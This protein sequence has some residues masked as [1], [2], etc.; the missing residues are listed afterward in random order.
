MEIKR[1][2]RG[3]LWL[4]AICFI[5]HSI[6]PLTSYAQHDTTLNQ[7][8][9]SGTFVAPHR[10]ELSD[11]FSALGT[12][13]FEGY[14]NPA[15]AQCVTL[16][17]ALSSN[18]NYIATYVPRVAGITNP[19]DPNNSTCDVMAT[20]Q[21]FDG[22]GRPV[23]TV[24]IKG[25]P[26]LRDMV[27]TINYDQFGRQSTKYLPFTVRPTDPSNGSFKTNAAAD[28]A[29]F[30]SNPSNPA[31]W[32]AAGVTKNQ[33]PFAETNFEPS[34]LNRITEQGS[35]GDAWQLP[36]KAGAVDPG[37]TVKI[38]YATNDAASL[39][40][41]SG[42]WAKLYSVSLDANGKPSLI[43]QGHYDV[44]QL[45]VT[46]TKD[47][48]WKTTDGKIGTVEQYTDKEGN[49]VLKRIFDDNGNAL[50]TYYIFD[51]LENL[52]YIL[53]PK[54][55]PDNGNIS[56]ATLDL[57]CYQY[58]FDERRR[59]V[60]KKLPGAG[61]E[62]IVYNK[63]DLAVATQDSMQRVTNKWTF[64]KYDGLSK[65]VISGV[66]DNGN[67][68]IS[69][70]SLQGIVNGQTSLWETRDN[71]NAGNYYYT[72]VAFPSSGI[73][74]YLTINY[75][76]DYGIPNLPATYNAVS[77]YSQ[78]TKGLVT[79]TLTNVLNTND[80]LWSVQ[81]YDDKGNVVK[82]FLQNYL[83]GSLN[84]ANYDE[85]S[86]T[87]D[88][89]HN[90]IT[91]TRNHHAGTNP[92]LVIAN[93]YDY[94]HSGRKINTWESIN[95]STPVL[96][97]KQDY[98]EV[99]QLLTKH[100]GSK[101]SGTSFLQDISYRYNERGWMNKDSSALFVMQ[102]QY[103]DNSAPEYNGN[104]STQLWGTGTTLN[105]S[106]TYTYDKMN[107]LLS[108]VSNEGFN[109]SGITYDVMGNIGSLVRDN[110]ILPTTTFAYNY[111]GNQLTTISGI[112][113]NPYQ[114]DG[115]GNVSF[116]PHNNI[117]IAYNQLNLPQNITGGKTIGYFYDA[118]GHKL[119][120]TSANTSIGDVDYVNGIQYRNGIVESVATEEGRARRNSDNSYTYEFNIYD[121]LGN[122]RISFDDSSS[123]ARVIQ[124]DDYYPFGLEINRKIFGTKNNN[125]FNG[126]ELQEEIGLYDF[127]AR[128]YDPFIGRMN[129]IDP[130][131]EKYASLSPY[132]F[133]TNNPVK[134]MD[135]DGRDVIF[136]ITRNKKGEITDVNISS[137][138][139]IQ[140]DGASDK[141][142]D[143]LTDFAADHL[144]SAKSNGVNVS[145]SVKYKYDKS[146]TTDKLGA[147]ENLMVFHAPKEQSGPN[148][149][150]TR[151]HGTSEEGVDPRKMDVFSS[152]SNNWT[153]LHETL[154]E[155]GLSDRYDEHDDYDSFGH[156]ATRGVSHPGFGNDLMGSATGRAINQAHYD[157]FLQAA[158]AASDGYILNPLNIFG[159][160]F[161]VVTGTQVNNIPYSLMVDKIRVNNYMGILTPYEKP[162]ATH[163]LSLDDFPPGEV[164]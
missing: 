117:T 73:S 107:R 153:V 154:H 20:V 62:Y 60:E 138:V 37:H 61:V 2:F 97:A 96:L 39:T 111:N 14:I 21:Y 89:T 36:G 162:S 136:T 91:T 150:A 88:F 47:E 76:D 4:T 7:P 63:I 29:S 113:S 54:A 127:G 118:S 44:N 83:G 94:D 163:Q 6:F 70:T 105:K 52:A 43:D 121:H 137:T 92:M 119:R 18:Q 9:Q 81:Y 129:M 28:Q 159:T 50:S 5:G 13:R 87:Y 135:P 125:L 147:G 142:A 56:Q 133:A 12:I 130:A 164:R 80:L 155:L 79:A 64:I 102:L 112:S 131:A 15:L 93:T 128:F 16:N 161:N 160:G 41:G 3:S 42:R 57:L 8:N 99:G 110:P 32:N 38:D 140:G 67:A 126:K 34:P 95:S 53:T 23:Q 145:F 141:R 98:N 22:L 90:L 78:M 84:T 35:A 27:Q 51:D 86:N 40:T 82:S 149:E 77:S 1:S 59:L 101:N 109:E 148:P 75:Y 26:T 11:G 69:R 10:I 48:N 19:A 65:S 158:K 157:Y 116:D 33:F 71:N 106:Y 72:S 122:T 134:R 151:S 144:K 55:A 115:N 143:E 156:K 66:W 104:I 152:G 24:Q 45:S 132:V 25:S 100:L 139:Y 114:Y 124:R 103:N 146:K 123:V 108:G 68:P 120:R 49:I 30:Y 74:K 17:T 58:R 31:T 85:I 46:V